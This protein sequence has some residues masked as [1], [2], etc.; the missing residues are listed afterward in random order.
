MKY[1]PREYQTPMTHHILDHE[2]CCLFAGMGT[3]KT[4]A[5]ATAIE[6]LSKVESEPVLVLAPLRVAQSTW[7]DEFA[8]W[9]H[10]RGLPVSPII[11]TVKERE[12]ALNRDAAVYTIN[13]ENVAWLIDTLRGRWPF[14]S[15]I[16]DE[17]TK[18]KGLRVSHQV[19]SK[20]KEFVTG[21]GAKRARLLAQLAHRAAR[22]W[23]NLT[24]T[25][26]PN[27]LQDLWGQMWFVDGGKRLGHSYS[28]FEQRWFTKGYDGFSMRPTESAQTEIQSR[29]SDVCLSIR[30]EDWFDLKAPQFRD[31]YIDLPSKVRDHYRSMEREMF[32]SID[33]ADITAVSAGAKTQKCLQIASGF[34]YHGEEPDRKVVELHDLKIA[35]LESIINESGGEPVLVAYQF[36]ADKDRLVKAFPKARLLDNKPQTIRDWNT[37]RIPILITHPASAGHGLNLQDGGRILVFF[38]V[39]WNLEEYQQIIER[40]GPTR[41]AQAGHDRVVFVYRIL[42]R[43]TVDELVLERLDGKRAVQDILMEA[44]RRGSKQ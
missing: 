21:Q 40:I 20:G 16:A 38:G 27:G 4:S 13:Y 8:K 36:Q 29:I 14:K 2:R 7:P 15:I 19:S 10:L 34:A 44:M 37:G 42:A 23:I 24:G 39:T 25:P 28:A 41:Q 26:A 22:R 6:I 33:G 1:T 30:A 3:G 32:A 17:S 43:D 9:D 18:L 12:R 31:V 35:A 11:G 5:A